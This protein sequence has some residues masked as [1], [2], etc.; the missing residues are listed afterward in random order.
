MNAEDTNL[1]Q[2]ASSHELLPRITTRNGF[3]RN[4]SNMLDTFSKNHTHSQM[5]MWLDMAM[6]GPHSRIICHK[7]QRRPSVRKYHGGVS[8]RW[9]FQVEFLLIRFGELPFS[10]P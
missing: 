10:I 6:E 8:V 1:A 9:V 7:P 5:Q 2:M 3:L 4:L